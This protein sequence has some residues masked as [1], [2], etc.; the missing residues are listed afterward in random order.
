MNSKTT[1][2]SLKEFLLIVRMINAHQGLG[3][4]LVQVLSKVAAVPTNMIFE[5]IG[6]NE[7]TGNFLRTF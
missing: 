5:N 7:P 3:V 4:K 6:K 1:D 2:R